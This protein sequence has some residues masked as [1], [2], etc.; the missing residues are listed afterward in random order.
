[1]STTLT[2]SKQVYLQNLNA[3]LTY[4]LDTYAPFGYTVTEVYQIQTSSGSVTAALQIN[5][6]NITGLSSISVTSTAQNVAATG[7]NTVAVGDALTLVFSSNSAAQNIQFTLSATR[8]AVSSVSNSDGTLTISPT[9]GDV[10]ASLAALTSAKFLVGNGS[11]VATGVAMSGDATLANTGAVTIANNKVT[12]AK[13]A[14]MAANTIK[15]NLT[16]STANASDNSLAA[17]SSALS[18]TMQSYFPGGFINKFRNAAF[19]VWQRGTSGT[20]TAGTPAYTADGW[21]VGCTGANVPWA[22]TAGRNATR[23]GLKVTG[24][25]SVTDVLIKQRIESFLAA[26]LYPNATAQVTVQAKVY[27]NTGSSITPTLTI[28]HAGSADNWSTPTTDVNAVSLQACANATLTTVAYTFATAS[29]TAN[30][31]E[32]TIDFG[33]NFSTSGKSVEVF[34]WDIRVTPGVA[35]GLNSAPPSPEFCPISLE[36]AVSQYY[37]PGINTGGNSVTGIA[38]GQCTNGTSAFITFFTPVA[39]R[40]PVNGISISSASHFGVSDS[41]GASHTCTSVT[42]A[43]ANLNSYSVNLTVASGLSAGNATQFQTTS[44]SANLVFTGAEL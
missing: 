40:V 5:G 41:T 2:I 13:A 16:G 15:G 39:T 10:V 19:D 42:F 8:N 4:D 3:G 36:Y 17:V 43:S 6:T 14:Q 26:Q 11:N 32:A 24:A 12:N 28:K 7:A 25:T 27:N 29:G 34:E 35:T 18:T 23:Y 38:Q 9:A 21:I 37:L 31:L 44:S 1:M 33:N 20:I 22:Q 30:G